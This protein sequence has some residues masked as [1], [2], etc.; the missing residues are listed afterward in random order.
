MYRH[1]ARPNQSRLPSQWQS[2]HSSGRKT[3]LDEPTWWSYTGGGSKI[4]NTRSGAATSY[5]SDLG[6]T[7][8]MDGGG[9]KTGGGGQVAKGGAKNAKSGKR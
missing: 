5:S 1:C 6:S 8:S 7:L 3:V 9:S 4:V 2:V